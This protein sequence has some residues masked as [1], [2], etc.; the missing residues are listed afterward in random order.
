MQ[1]DGNF[2]KDKYDYLRFTNECYMGKQGIKTVKRIAIKGSV[3]IV[4]E[5]YLT[6]KNIVIIPRS[7]NWTQIGLYSNLIWVYTVCD[8]L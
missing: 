3:K 7:E 1:I 5:L 8:W 2:S 4:I 6:L